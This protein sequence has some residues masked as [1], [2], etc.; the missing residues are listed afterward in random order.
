VLPDAFK[1]PTKRYAIP[2]PKYQSQTQRS[3]IYDL[4]GIAFHSKLEGI[5]ITASPINPSRILSA[6]YNRIN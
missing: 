1:F 3:V 5:L 2:P 6:S 4:P